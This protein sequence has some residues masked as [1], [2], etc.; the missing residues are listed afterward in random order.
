MRTKAQ[1]RASTKSTDTGATGRFSKPHHP[2]PVSTGRTENRS[3]DETPQP[4]AGVSSLESGRLTA[5]PRDS[6]PVIQ[7]KAQKVGSRANVAPVSPDVGSQLHPAVRRHMET[8]FRAD[9]SDVRIHQ[10]PEAESMG[11]VAYT[12]GKDIHFAPGQYDPA[13]PSGQKVIGHELAHVVQQRA[14]RVAMPHGQGT[15]I[16]KDINLEAEADLMGAKATRGDVAQAPWAGQIANRASAAQSQTP[17]QRPL[18]GK[19]YK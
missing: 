4:R 13:T 10:G 12:R 11:A 5:F 6:T 15:L 7:A 9:F 18:F 3:P 8:A 2:F 14:G 19:K 16:N 1:A 17:V